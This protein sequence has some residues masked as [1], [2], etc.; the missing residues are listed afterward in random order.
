M[1]ADSKEILANPKNLDHKDMKKWLGLSKNESW[2]VKAFNLE[3][4]RE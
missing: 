1:Y 3:E 4:A 2:D